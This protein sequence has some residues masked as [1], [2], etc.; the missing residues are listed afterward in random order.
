MTKEIDQLNTMLGNPFVRVTSFLD[1]SMTDSK[2]SKAY[3]IKVALYGKNMA[4]ALFLNWFDAH[5]EYPERFPATFNMVNAA[6]EAT[7][8]AMNDFD[9][10]L[11]STIRR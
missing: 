10:F 8:K 9:A 2:L 6:H 1:D 5:P 4:T 11:K 3:D 7:I